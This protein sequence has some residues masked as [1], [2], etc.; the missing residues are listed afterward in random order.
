MIW[1]RWFYRRALRRVGWEGVAGVA[2]L[3]VCGIFA[4]TGLLPSTARIAQL[5]DGGSASRP[6]GATDPAVQLDRFYRIFDRE[7]RLTDWL[8]KLYQIGAAT[9]VTLQQADYRMRDSQALRLI[10][11]QIALPVTASY[12]QLKQFLGRALTEIPGLSLDAVTLQRQAIGDAT[13]DA[14]LQ[15][16]LYLSPERT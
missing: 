3:M 5:Q 14:Q 1:L 15:F 6:I 9:G 12:P 7:E 16:T 2:L 8:A 4:L 11:Y 13:V 10:Q